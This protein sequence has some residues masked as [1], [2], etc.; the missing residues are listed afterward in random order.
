MLLKPSVIGSDDHG[1]ENVSLHGPWMKVMSAQNH[2]ELPDAS[3]TA[4]LIWK[5]P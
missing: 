5:G 4:G 2:L 3:M 1:P